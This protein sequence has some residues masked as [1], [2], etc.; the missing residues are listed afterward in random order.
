MKSELLMIIEAGLKK[1]SAKVKNYSTLLAKNYELTD[2]KFSREI[3]RIVNNNSVHPIFFDEFL[4]KP[5]DKDSNLDMVEIDID[6]TYHEGLIL[7]SNIKKSITDFCLTISKKEELTQFNL[8]LPNSLLLYGEPG[9]GKTAIAHLI[10]KELNMPLVTVKLDGLI[11]SLLGNT[12]KNLRKVFD[13]ASTKPCILFLD[14]FDA[15]AKLRSDST[16]LGELKRI[17]NSLLQN[18]D[19]FSK[20]GILI[21][22]TNHEKLLDPAI[23]RRFTTI[24]DTNNT[25]IETRFN[26]LE[27]SLN[28]FPM[29]FSFTESKK[30]IM[31]NLIKSIVPSEIK[32]IAIS[33]IRKAIINGEKNLNFIN[34]LDEIYHS[35]T[36]YK[37]VS[38]IVFLNYNKVSKNDISKYLGIS[39]RQTDNE[40]KR[41][42]NEKEQYN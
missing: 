39:L 22:A 36:S 42:E 1:N 31:E 12:A 15:I 40:L 2:P 30:K 21:A 32:K 17:V 20:S 38:F 4:T 34:I 5:Q 26:I 28:N 6:T 8:D 18:I 35:S 13:Y 10:S 23:W 3:L 37:D 24:I 7:D 14:E 11:S 9:T 29:D 19:S 27:K 33:S 25:S 16:E 41:S